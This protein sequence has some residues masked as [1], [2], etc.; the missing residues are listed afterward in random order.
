MDIGLFLIII[1]VVAVITATKTNKARQ[2]RSS[3]GETTASFAYRLRD[4]FL[5]PAELNFYK[6][7]T[8]ATKNWL[9]VCPKVSMQDVF[10]IAQGTKKERFAQRNRINRR[11]TD[12][13]ICSQNDM[14]PV[15]GIELDDKSHSSEKAKADDE[16]KN[17]VYES[18]G[19]PLLRIEAKRTYKLGEIKKAIAKAIYSKNKPPI[20]DKCNIP[21]MIRVGKQEN[22]FWGCCNFPQCRTTKE[23]TWEKAQP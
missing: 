14:K 10:F 4:D 20:C 21:L 3:S 11:H 19:L 23:F 6:C 16:V 18:A 2:K 7:L 5:S 8:V 13:L 17:K 22:L 12:F 15:L 9:V 1:A